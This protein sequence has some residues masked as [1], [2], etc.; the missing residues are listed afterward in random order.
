[1]S[2]TFRSNSLGT[3]N[4]PPDKSY[5]PTGVTLAGAMVYDKTKVKN[6]PTSWVQITGSVW[7][8]AIGT[9]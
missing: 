9:Q 1:M 2:R 6:P 7:K 5:V 3:K 4:I 8:G